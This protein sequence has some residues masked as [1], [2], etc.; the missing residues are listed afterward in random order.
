MTPADLPINEAARLQALFDYDILDTE[1]DEVFDQ[2]TDLASSICGKPIAL[3]S[4]IDEKRQWF[5]SH[6]GLNAQETPREVAFCAHAIHSDLLFEVRD[7]RKDE[8]FADNPLVTGEP[9]VIFYAGAP[10][11]T[12]SG[13]RIGTLCVIDNKPSALSELQKKQ[14][15]II[16]K[17]IVGQLELRKSNQ[18]KSKVVKEL[19]V[20]TKKYEGQQHALQK[21][22]IDMQTFCASLS[23]DFNGHIRRINQITRML[24][25]DLDE[26]TTLSD[27]DK[28]LFSYIEDGASGLQ[29]LVISLRGFLSI[30]YEEAPFEDVDLTAL[31]TS[32][33]ESLHH[34]NE[35][36]FVCTIDIDTPNIQ[37]N[38]GQL[39]ILFQN[40]L[41]NSIKYNTEKPIIHIHTQM[42]NEKNDIEVHVKDNG[43]G[44]DEK[45]FEQIF[46]P[47]R[48]LHRA[49]EYSGSGL[50]LSIV[51]RI[52]ERHR[53]HLT[54]ES[55][56]GEGSTFIISFP[57]PNT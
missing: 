50:G 15:E 42:N 2:L 4:L 11:I 5:K 45:Y 47:F 16:A 25:T 43:L 3:V 29:E 35:K 40:L 9:H 12:P 46:T 8:R 13:E 39:S 38:Y 27:K 44:I 19:G 22:N 49:D 56:L 41:S 31:I 26:K 55:T 18:L 36:S 21:S 14:L 33:E 20:L 10:L 53:G 28:Q 37:G 7:S 17:Q 1:S 32:V 52:I 51:K 57:I 23:H 24:H 34:S 6:H 48:R 30:D 54:I